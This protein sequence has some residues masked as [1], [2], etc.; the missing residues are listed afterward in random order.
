MTDDD[1]LRAL[2]PVVAALGANLVTTG[3]GRRGD[4]PVELEGRVVAY[5]RPGEIRGALE[6]AVEAVE[7]DLGAHLRDMS[8]DEKQNAVSRLDE[9]GAFLLRGAVEEIAGMMAVSRVT[10]YAYLNAIRES[11]GA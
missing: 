3:D 2:E 1:F 6:R 4:H 11:D 9:L 8:R 5:V 7:R 10:L